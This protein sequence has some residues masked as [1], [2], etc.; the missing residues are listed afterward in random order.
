MDAYLC[1][2]KEKVLQYYHDEMFVLLVNFY[3]YLYA[4]L[5]GFCQEQQSSYIFVEAKCLVYCFGREMT[6]LYLDSFRISRLFLINNKLQGVA[7]RHSWTC[8]FPGRSQNRINCALKAVTCTCTF[9]WLCTSN[10]SLYS[11]WPSVL[12]QLEWPS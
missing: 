7:G 12:D 5:Q 2:I 1:L 9:V 4:F 8:K 6:C 11:A 10:F 3:I